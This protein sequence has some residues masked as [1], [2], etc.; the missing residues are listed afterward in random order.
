MAN[1]SRYTLTFLDS[2][3]MQGGV[4]RINILCVH[5]VLVVL[6]GQMVVRVCP[7]SIDILKGSLIHI[8]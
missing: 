2:L 3:I 1:D 6:R 5:V 4:L 8:Y 7:Q